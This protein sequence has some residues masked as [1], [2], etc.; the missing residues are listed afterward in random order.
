V[1]E[2]EFKKVQKSVLERVGAGRFGVGFKVVEKFGD[3]VRHSKFAFQS[4][5]RNT[6]SLIKLSKFTSQMKR[7]L[8]CFVDLE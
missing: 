1:P 7:I 3:A 2:K 5:K 4:V 8:D 6:F